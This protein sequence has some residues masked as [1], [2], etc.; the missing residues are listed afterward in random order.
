VQLIVIAQGI[1]IREVGQGITLQAFLANNCD[2]KGAAPAAGE[3]NTWLFPKGAPAKATHEIRVVYKMADLAAALDI[4]DAFVVYEG[5]SRYGQ[6][7][8]FGPEGVTRVPDKK[9]FPINPWGVHFHMGYDATDTECI[10]DIVEHSVVPTEYD[11]I[12]ADPKDFL[13]A[14]LV[15]ARKNVQAQQKA[16]KAKKIKPKDVCAL[17]G[18]WRLMDVCQPALAAT[19]TARSDEPLL[20]RHFYVHQDTKKPEEF[21]TA[22]KVGSTDLD[23]AKLACTIFFMASCS[24]KVHFYKALTRRRKATKSACKFLLT[25]QVC[26]T[27]H[28]T[29]FLKQVLLKKRDPTSRGGIKKIKDALNGESQSGIV[30]VY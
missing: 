28:A 4:D 24:S 19:K 18:A 29:T 26:A 11:L 8:A 16:I 7:P 21:L 14:A 3:N 9:T 15:D 23:K 10:G 2:R 27:S 1:E 20:G 13:P 25:G 17:S 22:V 5:H 6:G 30:G 12:A